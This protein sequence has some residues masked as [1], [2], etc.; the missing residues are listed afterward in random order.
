MEKFINTTKDLPA[1]HLLSKLSSAGP[2]G[3]SKRNKIKKSLSSESDLE[4]S[5][6]DD[7]LKNK[8]PGQYN[9]KDYDNLDVSPEIKEIFQYITK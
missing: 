1:N 7:E 6:A 2:S 5:D 9:P 4:D 3:T 8:I